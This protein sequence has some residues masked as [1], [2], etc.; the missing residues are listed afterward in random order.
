MA[1]FMEGFV[2]GVYTGPERLRPQG[3]KKDEEDDGEEEAEEETYDFQ[4]L[5]DD[6]CEDD[7]L[8][9]LSLGYNRDLGLVL[10]L[11]SRSFTASDKNDPKPLITELPKRELPNRT[12]KKPIK[13]RPD[14]K[15]KGSPKRSD[16]RGR[17]KRRYS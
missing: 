8:V 15:S 9:D 3:F 14:G 2:L 5:E 7:D 10:S 6:S 1:S 4:G 17:N 12:S 16:K 11:E 13:P